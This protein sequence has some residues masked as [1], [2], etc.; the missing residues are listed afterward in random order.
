MSS[1]VST[2]PSSQAQGW[3]VNFRPMPPT[4]CDL[5]PRDQN[6]RNDALLWRFLEYVEERRLTLYPAQES[7][8]L[9]LFEEKNVILNTPTGSGKSLVATALHFKAIAQK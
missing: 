7:A 4:L 6:V 9:E 5:I 2:I 1:P 3:A 8:M